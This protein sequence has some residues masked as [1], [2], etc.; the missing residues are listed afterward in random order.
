MNSIIVVVL[1]MGQV[2]IVHRNFVQTEDM[3]NQLI[4]M[5]SKLDALEDMLERDSEDILSPA[6][7]LLRIHYQL[8]R[9]ETFRNQ[10]MHQAKKSSQDVQN[11][12]ARRFE[13]LSC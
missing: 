2:S 6:P 10:S 13:R 11:A 4:D 12:V 1:I 9:L 5:S 8:T 7:N 3:V